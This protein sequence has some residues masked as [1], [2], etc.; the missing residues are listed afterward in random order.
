MR[1]FTNEQLDL[2]ITGGEKGSTADDPLNAEQ[3]DAGSIPAASTNNPVTMA[4]NDIVA[5]RRVS[6]RAEHPPV[7]RE[8]AGS[9]PARGAITE[10]WVQDLSRWA[11]PE[12]EGRTY[13]DIEREYGRIPNVVPVDS[14]HEIGF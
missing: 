13:D 14:T 12:L 10:A 11:V 7:E 5:A 1:L 3:P 4:L 2:H 6:S 8:A 9:S